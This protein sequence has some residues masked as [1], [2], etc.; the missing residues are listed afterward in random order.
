MFS[1]ST[2][3]HFLTSEPTSLK[4]SSPTQYHAYH[5]ASFYPSVSPQSNHLKASLSN[6]CRPD[7]W[8]LDWG[9]ASLVSCMG[10][11]ILRG[12]LLF[13]REYIPYTIKH[14]S[15]PFLIW[16]VLNNGISKRR[17]YLVRSTSY[18]AWLVPLPTIWKIFWANYSNLNQT[19]S[20]INW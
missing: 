17:T 7:Q 11:H 1:S 13:G 20:T 16:S 8:E 6:K 2:F 3:P 18:K 14:F 9:R 5:H 4:L 19:E 10:F 12:H 15:T